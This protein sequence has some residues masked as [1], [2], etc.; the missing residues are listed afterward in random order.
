MRARVV[1]FL[2]LLLAA[3]QGLGAAPKTAKVDEEKKADV[4]SA[5]TFAG[6]KFRSIGPAWTSGRIGDFALDPANPARYF[7]AVASGGVWKTEDAGTTWTAIFDGEGSYSIGCLMLDPTNPNT[8]WVGTGENNSQRSVAWGDGVYRSDDGGKHWKNL[9]LKHSEHIGRIAIDPR[10]SRVVYVAAQGPLWAPGGDRGLYK[11]TDGGNTWNAVLTISENTG[12]SEV[13]MDPR[14]PDLLYAT[15]YQRRRHVWTMINGGPESAIYKSTDAGKSWRK[16]ENGLPKGVD[17][18]RIG[19]TV[20]PANPDVVYAIVEAADGKGGVF[21]SADR[22]ESWDKRGDYMSTSGQYYNELF[23]DPKNVDRVYSMDTWLHVTEDGGKTFT[24]VGE[25]TKHVDN[26]AMWID[27]ANTDHL[28]LGCDGGIYET[29]SRGKTWD[30]KAN[31]PVTQFYR[32]AVDGS[33]PF[34][35]VYGGTQDNFSMGGPSRTTTVSGI[36]NSDWFVTT[37]GDGFFAAIDPTDPN[38]VYSESQYGVLVRY[39]RRSGEEILIR[40]FEGK[41]EPPLRWNWDTPLI[42]SPH[43]HTRLYFAANKLFRSDDRGNTWKV[44]SGELSRGIDRNTLPV[45]G[46]VWPADAVAKNASTSFYGNAT[47]LSES[48]VVEGLLY[49]GTDDGLVHVSGD[50]GATWRKIESFPGVPAMTLVSRVEAS[51]HGADAVYAAFDNHK[52]GDFKPY[53]LRSNDRGRTWTSIAGDLPDGEVVYAVTEDT[54]EP[55]LLFA[56]CEFGAYFSLDGGGH[57][58]KLKGGMPTISVRDLAIQARENDLVLATFGRGF[59]ILDDLT[60]LRGLARA[61]L[62]K[63]AALFPVKDA[64]AYVESSPLGGKGKAFLG[65]S[66][67]TADN[68]PFGAVV[69]YYLKDELKTKKELRHDAEKEAEKKGIAPAYP[70]AEQLREE[71]REEKPSVVITVTDE[72]GNVVRRISAGPEKGIHRVSWDLRFPAPDPAKLPSEVT[73]KDPWDAPEQGPMVAPGV[74]RVS[75]AK[76]V[77]G[78][79]TDLAGPQQFQVVPLGL[80]TLGAQDRVAV[81]AFEQKA[82]RL[83]R[84]VLGAIEASKDARGRLARIKVALADTPAARPELTEQASA[85]DRRLQDIQVALSGDRVLEKHNEPTP[86]SIE[87]RVQLIVYSLWA[88]TQAPTQTMIDSYDIAG[89]EFGELLPKL[90]TLL[91]VDLKN[92][93]D[94]MEKA[95]APWTPGR[96]PT[97][98]KE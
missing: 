70:T 41:G 22:G 5:D 19:L 93:Q 47:A 12:V 27:P 67:F 88:T 49:V 28:L 34:Y 68:P 72:Q 82:A 66:F 51:R 4:M 63:P 38:I 85:N 24:R 30:F 40:P 92:L 96:V 75:L 95:G 83:Q 31:L 3:H 65:D 52:K 89:D 53:L 81:L 18:G 35:Y 87:D 55:G 16:L 14:N 48:P 21:R 43:S 15:A 39:D 11:S 58:I 33:K 9:G 69:T 84:A 56:G 2:I 26:H 1:P 20:S 90:R 7:V 23:C 80:A 8:V 62:E 57:W 36:V 42:I 97:W 59:Y 73:E 76:R 50:S 64:L 46:K 86:P 61:T 91:D 44:I 25:K 79:V 54:K 29:F 78:V 45:M 37:G 13:V 6:L 32:V 77:G 98:T 94:A 71:A 60:P 10:D 17:L 74:Y